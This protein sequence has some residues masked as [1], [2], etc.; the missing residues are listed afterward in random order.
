MIPFLEN[1]DAN[2]ALMGANMQRQAVPLMLTEAPIVATGIEHKCA[3][4]SGVVIMADG[5]GANSKVNATNITVKYY[6]GTW[7]DLSGEDG[8]VTSALTTQPVGI[9]EVNKGVIIGA[10]T[11]SADGVLVLES[12]TKAMVLPWV[13]ST[14]DVINP[15][16]G[17][18][19]YVSS[20]KM[21]AVFNG[22]SWA[23]WG[24]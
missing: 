22:T 15:S 9:I 20:V 19:V 18:M 13:E 3:V 24:S 8:D 10:N 16:P 4:D 6:N 1:D 14:D 21:L 11:S 5:D 2:R 12:D 23:F 7:Q 17:M